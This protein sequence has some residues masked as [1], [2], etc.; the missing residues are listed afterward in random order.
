MNGKR[1][2][3]ALIKKVSIKRCNESIY[4][5][6]NAFSFLKEAN[7][8]IIDKIWVWNEYSR[9]INSTEVGV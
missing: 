1:E 7:G 3:K 9:K 8:T 6:V 2:R 4:P 5:R